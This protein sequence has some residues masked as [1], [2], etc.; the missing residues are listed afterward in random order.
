MN[1]LGYE[2]WKQK[3][4]SRIIN[5][6]GE[7][8]FSDKHVLELGAGYGTIG[9][10]LMKLGA[11]VT[12]ADSNED[13]LN[14]IQSQLP[15]PVPL[16]KLDQ[17]FP[18]D[19]NQNFD[20]VLHMGVLY[21]LLNWKEDLKSAFSHSNKIILET[22]VEH[23]KNE[24]W[25]QEIKVPLQLWGNTLNKKTLFSEKSVEYEIKNLGYTYLPL[26]NSSLDTNFNWGMD[27]VNMERH[28]YSWN[29]HNTDLYPDYVKNNIQ[30]ST[31]FRRMWFIIK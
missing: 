14:I 17:N 24:I 22:I 30:Y 20:L 1:S 11:H 18:Y 2:I 5:L 25:E 23:T 16:I 27:E 13:F 26:Y 15:Q 9:I 7:D 3:R 10:E 28:I 31:H 12:F 21:H 19:L 6:L 8:W 4:L 29:F